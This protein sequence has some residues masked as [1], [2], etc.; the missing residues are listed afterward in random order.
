[1]T[2]FEKEFGRNTMRLEIITWNIPGNTLW[3]KNA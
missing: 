1:M 3:K 2:H